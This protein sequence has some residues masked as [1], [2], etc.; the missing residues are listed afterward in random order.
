MKEI[1]SLITENMLLNPVFAYTIVI[2]Y[3]CLIGSFLNVVIYRLPIMMTLE[4]LGIIKEI[5][6]LP[7]DIITSKMTKEEKKEYNEA[8]KNK[9]INLSLPSSRCG[10]CGHK[11]AIW[12]NIPVLSYLLLRGKCAYCHKSYSPQ[13]LIIELLVG[14]FWGYSYYT[15][16]LTLE[17]IMLTTLF[18]ALI[19]SAAIDLKHRI[20]PDSITF[21][22]LFMGLYYNTVSETPFVNSE[23]AITGAILGYI[24]IYGFVK[25]YEK[26]RGIDIAMGEGD[27]KLYAMIGAWIGSYDLIMLV[28]L[29]TFIGVLQFIILIPFKKKLKDYQLPFGPAIILSFFL[30]TYY[31]DFIKSIIA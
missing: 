7:D 23:E 2:I 6:E 4:Y 8:M 21:A 9:G 16:G 29:S 18:T 5:T 3:G 20:L 11:I 25:G 24:V 26:L 13:Y 27:I 28:V 22:G 19:A 10:A 17:F 15:L 30:F 14:L 1:F 31:G 12:H